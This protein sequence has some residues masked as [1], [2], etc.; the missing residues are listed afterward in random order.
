MGLAGYNAP[1]LV[2]AGVAQ[3]VEHDVA[4]VDVDGSNPFARSSLYLLPNIA[5]FREQF[6]LLCPFTVLIS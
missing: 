4:N 6:L 5:V 1:E 3:L 2:D